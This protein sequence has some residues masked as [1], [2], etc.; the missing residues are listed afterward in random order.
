MKE[1][2]WVQKYRPTVIDE[3]ILPETTKKLFKDIVAKGEMPN[4]ILAGTAGVGKTTV[5]LALASEMDYESMVINASLESGIDVI[6]VKLQQFASSVSFNGNPKVVILDE[7]DFLNGNSAQPALRGFIEEFSK[8]CRFIFTCNYKTRLIEPLHSRCTV[9]EFAVS[10]DNT[11]ELAK[12]F[13]KRVV[14]I[15]KTEEIEFDKN[16]V[17]ELVMK[18]FPDFRRTLNE[19]QRYSM[20]GKIDTGILVNTDETIYE[21]LIGFL[22]ERKFNDVRKWTAIHADIPFAE[23]SSK[24]YALSATKMEPSSIPQLVMLLADYDYKSAFVVNHE[25]NMTAALTEIMGQAKWK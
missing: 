23:L 4:L 2:L 15:L 19:L 25:I 7:A 12:Q 22:K 1:H 24:L 17:I 13:Y 10:K 6:R 3:C 11:P 16:V 20:S 14:T 5:A 18:H 21:E 9:V 8:N